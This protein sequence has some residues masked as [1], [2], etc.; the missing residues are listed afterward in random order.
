MPARSKTY[1]HTSSQASTH[2]DTLANAS[3]RFLTPPHIITYQH[4]H[5]QAKA[6]HMLEYSYIC[7][8]RRAEQLQSK[9]SLKLVFSL[10][11]ETAV[12]VRMAVVMRRKLQFYYWKNRKFHKLQEDLTVPDVPR[13]LA[14][15][16]EALC[17]G[18]R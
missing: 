5:A 4:T 8:P 7:Q 10:T 14:W 1:R 15:A 2:E 9:E 11:G 12:A 13:S 18:T 17:L 16:G 3:K 6:R